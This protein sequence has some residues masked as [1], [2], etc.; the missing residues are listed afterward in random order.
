MPVIINF[1]SNEGVILNIS[2]ELAW[3]DYDDDGSL[4]LLS[5]KR[6]LEDHM[7]VDDIDMDDWS[8]SYVEEN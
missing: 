4:S 2:A 8:W 6:F 5:A 3:D 1:Q 7:E